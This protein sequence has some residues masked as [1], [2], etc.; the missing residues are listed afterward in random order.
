MQPSVPSHEPVYSLL[1]R[2]R[3]STNPQTYQLVVLLYSWS[4]SKIPGN[5]L[6]FNQLKKTTII[7]DYIMNVLIISL[8]I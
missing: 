7:I 2:L 3:K 4:L 8:I 1:S 6:R 5:D